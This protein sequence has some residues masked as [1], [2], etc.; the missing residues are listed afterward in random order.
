MRYYPLK[1]KVLNKLK[2]QILEKYPSIASS[3]SIVKTGYMLEE[4]DVHILVIENYPSFITDKYGSDLIPTLL[5]VKRFGKSALPSVV[6]DEGAV[7]HIL[8]GADVMIPGIIEKDEFAPGAVVSVWNPDSSTPIAVG[9]ALISSDQITK[10]SKGRAIKT[11]HYAGD[12]AWNL[13]IKFLRRN[14]DRVE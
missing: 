10:G 2:M 13:S 7:P 14:A 8:N 9:K 6:V 12:R 11:L 1:K 5:L 4:K 3:L